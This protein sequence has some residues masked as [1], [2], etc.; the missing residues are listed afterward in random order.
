MSIL[1]II[2]YYIIS[3]YIV[4]YYTI[5]YQGRPRSPVHPRQ[6][7]GKLQ[8]FNS[9][10]CKSYCIILYFNVLYHTILYQGRPRPPVRPSGVVQGA[11]APR[12]TAR[13]Q[14]CKLYCIFYIVFYYTTVPRPAPPAHLLEREGRGR[15]SPLEN[16]KT[17]ILGVV[18]YI[19]LYYSILH[20]SILYN[21]KVGPARPSARG[22]PQKTARFQF[23]EL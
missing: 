15:G 20:D 9:G 2:L 19:V 5:L 11:A 7:P 4:L 3:Q 12:K 23:W 10:D 16:S 8:D 14:F 21:T 1:K 18:N 17:S 6:P 22:S 13:F